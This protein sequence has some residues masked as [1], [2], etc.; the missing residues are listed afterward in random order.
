MVLWNMTRDVFM[1]YRKDA[2]WTDVLV[3]YGQRGRHGTRFSAI[4]KVTLMWLALLPLCVSAQTVLS[5]DSC[6]S[7]ALRNN[8]TLQIAKQRIEKAQYDQKAAYTNY[9]PNFTGTGS[10]MYSNKEFSLLSDDQKS[11]L[12]NLG[13]NVVNKA[14]A[15]LPSFLQQLA[16]TDPQLATFAQ[17]LIASGQF[18]TLADA[19]NSFGQSITDAFHTDTKNMW[20]GSINVTQPLYMGGKIRA[21]N[22]ITQFATKLAESQQATDMQ[23]VILDTDNAYWTAVSLAWKKNLA[24]SYLRLVKT[25]DDDVQKMIKE[26]VATKSDGLS[27]SVKVNEAEMLVTQVDNGLSLSKML[28]CEICGMPITNQVTLVDE[29]KENIAVLT[30]N[31]TADVQKAMDNRPELKSLTYA[32]EIYRQKENV[33]RA[34]FLPSLSLA[35]NYMVTNPS[36]Y[37]GFEK[38]FK[39][40]FHVGLLL[41]VPIFHWNEWSYKVHSAKAETVMRQ[42]ELNDAKD[43]IALQVNQSVFRVQDANKRLAMSMKNMEKAEENLRYATLSFKEGVATTSNVLEAQT[44]WRQAQ[45]DKIDA[46][47]DVKMTQTYLQ[48]SLGVLR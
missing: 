8:K 42:L 38:K 35:G 10:Y 20:V 40:S 26:G 4:C 5:L 6:R 1:T 21:Y 28:L 34:D 36:L 15:S 13:T 27:V 16:Q 32:T 31:P 3:T 25:L 19:L 37:N 22:K 30:E 41:Q 43:K 11:A 33:T 18:S 23:G 29:T 12:N 14:Q 17:Q 45:S 9:L 46:E 2:K 48:K 24:E 39:G 7:M 44:A 47:V